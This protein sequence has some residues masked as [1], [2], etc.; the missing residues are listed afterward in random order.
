VGSVLEGTSFLTLSDG[1]LLPSDSCTFSVE[2]QVPLT[3][4]SGS[5]L[6]VTSDL[7]GPGGAFLAEPATATLT[8]FEP[9]DSDGDGVLDDDD[10]CPGTVIPEGVPT[11]RLGVNRF[12]LVDEDHIF[13]TTPP[14]GRGPAVEFTT[15]DTAGCSCEQIIVE[16]DLG[17]GHTKF[18]CSLG[19]MRDWVDLVAP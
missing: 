12:A 10:F 13:D 17:K 11:V 19:A 8:V 15:A 1:N 2:L 3:T 18:G 5:Y 9:I 4:E 6:N 14:R 16:M 7:L